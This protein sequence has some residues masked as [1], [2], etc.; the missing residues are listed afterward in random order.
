[1]GHWP[2]LI[3][4]STGTGAWEPRRSV[5]DHHAHVALDLRS[6]EMLDRW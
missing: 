6:E 1:M 3:W 5:T 4:I 2:I